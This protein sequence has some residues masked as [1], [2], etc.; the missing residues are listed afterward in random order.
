MVW[1][2][3]YDLADGAGEQQAVSS[4]LVSLRP[5]GMDGVAQLAEVWLQEGEPGWVEADVS[6][7]GRVDF[8]DFAVMAGER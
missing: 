3:T 4:V 8:G 6:A 5:G 2:I 1:N 7:D